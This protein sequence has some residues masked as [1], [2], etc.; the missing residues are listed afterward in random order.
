MRLYRLVIL[1]PLF[2]LAGCVI[3]VNAHDDEDGPHGWRDRQERNER[4]INHLDL[5]RTKVSI[6]SQLGSPDFVESF[7]RNGANFTVLYYRTRH[8][9]SD[10]K[11]TKDET[12]P[13]VFVDGKL[14]GWGQSAID[15]A[16]VD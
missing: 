1:L 8:V 13:L 10:G 14:V 6:E 11:T 5:S 9:H 15:H 2:W 12:T 7:V 16:T 4:A 3:S